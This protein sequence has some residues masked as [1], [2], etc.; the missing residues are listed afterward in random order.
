MKFNPGTGML[1]LCLATVI[2][3]VPASAQTYPTKPIHI[4]VP[5]PPGGSN[6]VLARILAQKMS[7]SFGQP[8]IVEN[9]PGAAGNIATDFIAKAEGDGY[10]IAVAPNQTVAVNPVLYPRLPFEVSRDLTGIS[11]LGRVP[12]VLV[13][14]PG[15]VA[16]TSVAELI[17]LAKANPDKLSYA[18]AGSGS[19][20]HMAAEVFKSMTGTRITQIPYKGSAPALV[21]LLGGNVDMMFCP[22]NSALPHIRSGKLRALGTSGAKRV[23]LLPKVP[24]IAETLPNFESDIWIG[25]VAPARTPPAIINKLNAE[26]RRSL[27]LPD[28]QGKLAEQ[29]IY[30]E[31]STPLEFT[32]LI[33][34]D[35]KRWA[36]VIRAANIKPE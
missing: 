11:L 13:V 12:M 20:Q 34:S 19:P 4:V 5:L 15:K 23:E 3:G 24:T 9:K 36:E 6:D 31:T 18:S 21:D 25:M 32:R 10:S 7:E 14:S 2:I 1:A 35:Q 16:A 26:L 17:A 27:A 8:V 22:I 30:A 29:G 33:A 28:V